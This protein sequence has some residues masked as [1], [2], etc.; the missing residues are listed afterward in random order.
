MSYALYYY[1][2]ELLVGVLV[3]SLSYELWSRLQRIGRITFVLYDLPASRNH[4][5]S[6]KLVIVACKLNVCV[7]YEKNTIFINFFWLN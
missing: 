7:T 1:G 3:Q 2:C 4:S 6:N 5:A